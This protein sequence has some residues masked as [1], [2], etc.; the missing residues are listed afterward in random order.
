MIPKSFLLTW[1][2]ERREEIPV[3]YLLMVAM[4]ILSA[5]GPAVKERPPMT[6]TL[7]SLATESPS[8]PTNTYPP[9]AMPL[10]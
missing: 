3:I 2:R 5:C 7:N 6:E 4:L 10:G 9:T 8:V 1:K